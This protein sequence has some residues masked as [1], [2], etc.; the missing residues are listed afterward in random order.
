MEYIL[1]AFLTVNNWEA[2]GLDMQEF[3]T[4]S[5]CESAKYII[6]K[7]IKNK[8]VNIKILECIKK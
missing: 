4:K 1:I 6:T 3:N 2:G 7:S 5:S 8:R